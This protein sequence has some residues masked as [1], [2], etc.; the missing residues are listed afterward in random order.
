MFTFPFEIAAQTAFDVTLS[1]I[2][3]PIAQRFI[4]PFDL[5]IRKPG[6]IGDYMRNKIY[7]TFAFDSRL[8]PT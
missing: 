8:T 2:T 3:N 6:D 4:E 7:M 5:M 1:G